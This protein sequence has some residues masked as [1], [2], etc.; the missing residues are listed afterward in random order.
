MHMTEDANRAGMVRLAGAAYL[1]IILCGVWAE[2][3]VR[4]GLV[5]PGDPAG[6]ASAIRDALPLFRASMLADAIMAVADIIVA[7]LLYLLL[8]TVSPVLAL[9]ATAFR[10]VQA[11]VIGASLVLLSAVPA[12]VTD[13]QDAQAFTFLSLHATGYDIGLVFFGVNGLLMTLLLWRSPGT[14]RII[15]AGIGGAALVYLAGSAIRLAAP[16]LSAAFAPAYALPLLAESAF[17]LW[18]LLRG[19]V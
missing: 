14:P 19:R 18:L 17:C 7:I 5:A 13:Q 1:V 3:V 16:G 15:A 2:G 10:L 12:L 8:R 6:T 11:A 4:S 9:L